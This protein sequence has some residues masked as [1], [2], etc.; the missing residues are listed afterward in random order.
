[1]GRRYQ[2]ALGT[3]KFLDA[4]IG[5]FLRR[6]TNQA[7][8]NLRCRRQDN[9]VTIELADIAAFNA[10]LLTSLQQHP[11]EQLPLLEAAARDASEISMMQSQDCKKNGVYSNSAHYVGPTGKSTSEP[12]RNSVVDMQIILHSPQLPTALRSLTADHVGRLL[13]I[14]GIIVSM[15]PCH[16]KATAH[17][18]ISERKTCLGASKVKPKSTQVVMK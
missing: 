14:S 10:E 5:F 18:I 16:Q 3:A 7:I 17:M 4:I 12:I 8:Y 2:A 6:Q 13:K 1:M 15:Y 11:D 9:S